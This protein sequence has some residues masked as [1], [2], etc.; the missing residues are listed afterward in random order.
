MNINLGEHFWLIAFKAYTI[1]VKVYLVKMCPIFDDSQS[2]PVTRYQKILWG[3]SFICKN[4]FNSTC[5]TMRFHNCHH[6]IAQL[7]RDT[8][9]INDLTSKC[10]HFH[11][12]LIVPP[13]QTGNRNL[14]QTF[15]QTSFDSHMRNMNIKAQGE[16]C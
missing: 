9:S 7:T 11:E 5:L 4:L 12:L 1:F 15:W 14:R 2:N 16:A 13:P 3:C 8:L 10:V 6:T